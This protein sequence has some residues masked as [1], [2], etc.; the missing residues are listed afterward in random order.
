MVFSAASPVNRD[1]ICMHRLVYPVVYSTLENLL[2]SVVYVQYPGEPVL[3]LSIQVQQCMYSTLKNLLYVYLSGSSSLC[4]VPWRTCYL[5]EYLGSVVYVQYPGEPALC[6]PIQ[7]QMYMYSTPE[8]LLYVY[9]SWSSSLCTVPWKTCYFFKYLGFM[10]TYLGSVVYVQYPG[11]PAICL[12]IQVQQCM[13][14][15]LEKLLF[16]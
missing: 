12:N 2:G 7:V 15:T 6:L 8:N 11:E 10:F 3:C 9:L 1:K 5:F 4:T 16:V 14:S 13:Y